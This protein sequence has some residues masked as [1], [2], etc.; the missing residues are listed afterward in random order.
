[1][2]DT[3]FKLGMS[4][5]GQITFK[6]CFVH[7][8]EYRYV[9]DKCTEIFN[10]KIEDRKRVTIFEDLFS[11]SGVRDHHKQCTFS[12]Y[13]VSNN[14]Q[15]DLVD[16]LKGMAKGGYTG[17]IG[18]LG[19][20]GTGKNHLA[21]ATIKTYCQLGLVAEIWEIESLFFK[22][23][24]AKFHYQ[25]RN[26][27]INSFNA[28]SLLII[29]EITNNSQYLA[30]VTTIVNNRYSHNKPTILLGNIKIEV[31]GERVKSRMQENGEFVLAN[32]DDY[33]ET[34]KKT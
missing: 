32:W 3:M 9:C 27:S 22:I 23:D 21:S 28:P 10:K 31:L 30:L 12:T 34:S 2:S 16:I 13:K 18:I 33:R 24:G 11:K 29:D 4:Q 15:K 7:D 17:I 20:T 19:N 6:K 5:R 8:M 26:E 14:K 25:D 1:M